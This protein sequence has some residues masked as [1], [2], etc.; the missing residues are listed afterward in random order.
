MQVP[1]LHCGQGDEVEY[2]SLSLAS[3]SLSTNKANIQGGIIVGMH[4]ILA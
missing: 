4:Q 3:L 2:A 1:F